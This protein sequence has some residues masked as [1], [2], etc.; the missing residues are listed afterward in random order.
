[1][2]GLL[3]R[4]PKDEVDRDSF[5]GLPD[6][7]ASSFFFFRRKIKAKTAAPMRTT[8]PAVAPPAMAATGG[9][10]LELSALFG[11]SP[12]AFASPAESVVSAVG[13]APP[14]A[15][16]LVPPVAVG[17]GSTVFV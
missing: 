4:F 5:G 7:L 10:L 11:E 3:I 15:L 8:A 17:P 2:I 1:M 16:V 9:P 12:V 14:V 6:P 13:L